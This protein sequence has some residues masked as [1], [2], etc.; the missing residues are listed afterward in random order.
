MLAAVA[1][2]VG[3][4]SYRHSQ[5]SRS[6]SAVAKQ[7]G[8]APDF[9]L[10]LID[11][12]QLRLSSYR[13]K[14]ILLDF[15]ATWCVPCREE[16]PHFVDLQQKYG[17]EGLQIIGVSMDDSADPV[18]TFYQQFHM[19]YPVVMGTADVGGAYGGVLGLPIAFLIDREGRI[20]AK[21][22]GATDA[23]V[24]DKDITARLQTR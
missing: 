4:Y 15:W 20:Y 5:G 2:G 21:H 16:T 12:G 9:N 22:L 10:P 13:G 23:A 14:V 11:G 17:G 19:N 8:P 18:R 6:D 7:H 24:F 3:I 1:V